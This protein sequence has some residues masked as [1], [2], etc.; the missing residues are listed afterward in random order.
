MVRSRSTQVMRG[1]R[2]EMFYNVLWC[3]MLAKWEGFGGEDIRVSKDLFSIP[4]KPP[5]AGEF[6]P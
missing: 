4:E 2:A 5:F 3:S 1:S 6:C